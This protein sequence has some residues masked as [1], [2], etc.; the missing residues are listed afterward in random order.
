MARRTIISTTEVDPETGA[1]VPGT[2]TTLLIETM[3]CPHT[4]LGSITR[5][6]GDDMQPRVIRCP[7][8]W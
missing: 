6:I 7:Y 4:C 3:P 1:G 5:I 2:G 8:C